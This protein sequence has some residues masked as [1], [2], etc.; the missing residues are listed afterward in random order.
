MT[1][2]MLRDAG[3]THGLPHVI[4]RYFNVAGAD[5]L[6][7]T[8]QSTKRASPVKGNCLLLAGSRLRP[9]RRSACCGQ[10]GKFGFVLPMYHY[11]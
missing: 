3:G 5:P 7:R 8:G 11:R 10:S 9:F 2:I 4:L 6:D 1:E